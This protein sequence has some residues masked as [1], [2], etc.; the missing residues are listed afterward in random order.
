M[1]FG[2]D[3]STPAKALSAA[4]APIIVFSPEERRASALE[5]A[6]SATGSECLQ[7]DDFYETIEQARQLQSRHP[8]LILDLSE[9]CVRKLSD[10]L[11]Q[12][13]QGVTVVM[14]CEKALQKRVPTRLR[15]YSFLVLE[16]LPATGTTSAI[17]RSARNEALRKAAAQQRQDRLLGVIQNA[18][19][20]KFEFSTLDEAKMLAE[21]LSYAFPER[22][23]ARKG[24]WE[25]MRNAVEHGN[26]EIG[27]KEKARLLEAGGLD[28]EI[29]RRLSIEPYESRKAV[30]VLARK[31]NGVYAIIKD[32]G[33]GFEWREFTKFSP[34]RA[35]YKN[36]RGIQFA[37]ISCFD[38]LAYNDAGNQV[39]VRSSA[40]EVS[41][42]GKFEE[43]VRELELDASAA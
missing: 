29:A 26:L 22:D 12:D 43:D 7:G 3:L 18:E 9:G 14:V 34:A 13:L 15:A 36:G 17:I 19:T 38:S 11:L 42:S 30:V 5:A 40:G 24:L 25:L 33:P 6:I 27:F 2:D 21:F 32:Q 10:A 23:H 39:S 35:S 1:S 31:E 8:V 16:D 28:A 37:R 20:A 41:S 4:K